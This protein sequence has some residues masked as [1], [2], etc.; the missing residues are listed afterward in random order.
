MSFF[1]T[2][3]ADIEATWAKIFGSGTGQ[4]GATVVSDIKIVGSAL[5]GA[6]ASFESLTG[7]DSAAVATIQSSV[8]AI[9]AGAL[10]VV[11]GI[12]S[13]VAQPIVTQI[14]NDFNAFKGALPAT[15]PTALANIMKAI[16]TILPYIEAGVG[17]LTAGNASAS[18]TVSASEATGMSADEARLILGGA[19]A[20]AATKA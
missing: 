11:V 12:E 4:L 9:E 6:L 19:A 18:A 20:V 3:W 15:L 8:A 2:L 17:L 16:T 14:V 1:S 5:T 7:L 13:N 10:Q